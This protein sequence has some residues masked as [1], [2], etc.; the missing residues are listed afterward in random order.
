MIFLTVTMTS[1]IVNYRLGWHTPLLIKALRPGNL[2]GYLCNLTMPRSWNP[3]I[4]RTHD[5]QSAPPEPSAVEG[6]MQAVDN[7]NE[8]LRKQPYDPVLW[9]ERASY[10]LALNYPELAVGD[11]YKAGLLFD[12]GSNDFKETDSNLECSSQNGRM[13]SR[14]YNVLGQALYDCH[15]H[16]E[17]AEFWEEVSKKIPGNYARDKAAG[18]RELLNQKEKIAVSLG[19]SS[20]ERKDRLRDGGVITVHYPWLQKRH[21]T[22][23]QE[24]VT[25][26]NQELK[27]NV[28]EQTCYLSSSTLA[29]RKDMLG[30]FAARVVQPGECI[31]IDRTATGICSIIESESCDNCYVRVSSS[32]KRASCCSAVYCSVEC[33]DLAISTYH[34]ALCGQDFNWLFETAKGLQDNA[35]ALRPLL[36]LRF[37][38]ACVQAGVINSPL[39]HPLIAR[40]QPLADHS[41]LDVFTFTESVVAPTK[42]LQQLGVDVFAEPNFDIMVLHTIWT[43]IANNKAGS[44]DLRRGFIDEITPLL[45]LFNHSCEPNIEYKRDDSSTTIRFFA[46][47][48]IARDQELFISYLNVENTSLEQRS[49]K[50]WPWFEEPCLCSKCRRETAK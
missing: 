34:K 14:A 3:S 5:A 27:K 15:C 24:I 36:M 12:H 32:P 26:V 13:D 2:T 44:S 39:D 7:C 1:Y 23:S 25:L 33:H 11:A 41:H 31:L 29:P 48:R 38:A 6:I 19:G 4:Y 46:K 35:S 22:R 16:W 8:R 40:L 9:T 50:L 49:A 20:Q 45:P 10:F 28:V 47:R 21:V 37:L 17:A 43:R 42:I 18:I 30:M